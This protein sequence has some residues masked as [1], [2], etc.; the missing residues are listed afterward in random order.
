MLQSIL[1]FQDAK[2]HSFRSLEVMCFLLDNAK[3]TMKYLKKAKTT[4]TIGLP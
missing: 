2:K 3:S 1:F 4:K